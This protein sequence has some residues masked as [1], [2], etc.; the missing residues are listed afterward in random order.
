[1]RRTVIAASLFLTASAPVLAQNLEA[2]RDGLNHLPA[3]IFFGAQ[4]DVAYFVDM[5]ALVQDSDGPAFRRVLVGADMI[6]LQSL[7]MAEPAEWESKAGTTTDKVRYFTAFGRPPDGHTFWGL[8]DEAAAAE[9][10]D[11]L[12]TLGFETAGSAG[13]VGNGEPQRFAPDKRDST[14]PWRTMVGAAQ[15][16]AAKGNNVVQTQTPQAAMIAASEQPSLTDNAIVQTALNGLE[17]AAGDSRVV[18]AVVISPLFGVANLDPATLLG[19]SADMEETRQKLQAQID[20][21]GAGIPPYLGGIVADLEADQSGVG[22][23][24]AYPDCAIAG[25]AADTIAERWGELAD[26]TAQGQI[27][28][29]TAEG[30]EGLCAATVTVSVDADGGMQNPAYRTV[31]DAYMRRGPSVLQIGAS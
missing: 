21:L 15:F 9:M 5:E 4:G 25:A 30:L 2:L 31:L 1:M 7:S 3:T 6:P 12:E 19:P 17:A 13:V 26:G 8:T 24:L 16:A 10:I 22:I 18:Q 28:T 23:A 14:D 27:I 29:G 20:E 11:T